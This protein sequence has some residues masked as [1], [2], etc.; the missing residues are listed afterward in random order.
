MSHGWSEKNK[1]REQERPVPFSTPQERAK[2]SD[3]PLQGG[4]LAK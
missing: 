4:D 1:N 2:D 3:H